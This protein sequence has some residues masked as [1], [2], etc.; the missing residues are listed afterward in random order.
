MT[1]YTTTGAAI[2]GIIGGPLAT[3]IMVHTSGALGLKGWQWLFLVEGVPAIVT[4]VSRA[5]LDLDDTPKTAVWLSDAQK[6]CRSDL[7]AEGD[8]HSQHGGGIEGSARQ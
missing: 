5:D 7:A 4:G 8:D 6:N 1:A 3:W 2:A